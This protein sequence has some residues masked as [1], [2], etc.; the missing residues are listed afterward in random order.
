MSEMRIPRLKPN[1]AGPQHSMYPSGQSSWAGAGSGGS[2]GG[3]PDVIA[4]SNTRRTA[5]YVS[6]ASGLAAGSDTGDALAALR[7]RLL[8]QVGDA[9]ASAGAGGAA[10]AG[11][12]TAGGS[13]SASASAPASAP[14]AA[15]VHMHAEGGALAA[16]P[17]SLA[18]PVMASATLAGLVAS[19]PGF[20]AASHALPQQTHHLAA[21]APGTLAGSG[22]GMGNASFPAPVYATQ[23]AV[24]APAYLPGLAGLG[25]GG[26]AGAGAGA[27]VATGFGA[28]PGALALG[29]GLPSNMSSMPGPAG[30]TVN[31]GSTPAAAA[32]L[33]GPGGIVSLLAAVQPTRVLVLVNSVG[34][35]D[36]SGPA[37]GEIL[38]DIAA[39]AQV[40]GR[41][42]RAI[43]P[44][45]R[46]GET[47]EQRAKAIARPASLK[48]AGASG[49][50]EDAR[51]A[52]AGGAGARPIP[53]SAAEF[54][55]R[56]VKGE[57]GEGGSGVGFGDD[58]DAGG[59]TSEAG[60]SAP[61]EAQQR[62]RGLGKVFLEFEAVEG[63][64]AAQR[65][66][67]GR[68]FNGRIVLSTFA[69]EAS[70][71][72]GQLVDLKAGIV[73]SG[74]EEGTAASTDATAA[75][76]PSASGTETTASVDGPASGSGDATMA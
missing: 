69:D 61:A 76:A 8:A 17:S 57:G 47:I 41:L 53:T 15:D 71:W 1:G 24:A 48:V 44:L 65:E 66:L 32:G 14:S 50:L 29:L 36:I 60:G 34:D 37:A 51:D 27:G 67:S 59:A 64:T 75:P 58:G 25:S 6:R 11:A 55:R 3:A 35:P 19:A 74:A 63:A 49:L 38:A 2:G 21:V 22:A 28:M 5:D 16:P 70:F 33:L 68:F 54:H 30:I 39:E 12:A 46:P 73:L 45:P 13:A 43:L 10:G 23:A 26:G 42:L 20:P 40:H 56:V 31:V 72:G 4:L 18:A 7:A 62:T 52:L 9:D